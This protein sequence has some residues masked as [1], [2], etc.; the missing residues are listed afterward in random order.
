MK[1]LAGVSE[2]N[3]GRCLESSAGRDRSISNWS[4]LRLMNNDLISDSYFVD[5][6]RS[7]D[8]VVNANKPEAD[9]ILRTFG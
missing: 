2:R 4:L 3:A 5:K 6:L 1:I 9:I 8:L 7:D